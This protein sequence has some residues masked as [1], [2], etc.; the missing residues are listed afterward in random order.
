MRP[1]DEFTCVY[2]LESQHH[3]ETSMGFVSVITLRIDYDD[4]SVEHEIRRLLNLKTRLGIG[5]D[6]TSIPCIIWEN[7]NIWDLDEN[8]LSNICIHLE[9]KQSGRNGSLHPSYGEKRT[10]IGIKV[11]STYIVVEL[12][13]LGTETGREVKFI[14]IY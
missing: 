1:T 8:W 13:G 11:F 6:G 4:M 3:E 7:F 2:S 14:D 5:V 12:K 9:K 10:L